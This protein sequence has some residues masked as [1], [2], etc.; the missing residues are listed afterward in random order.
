MMVRDR[1][2]VS[3]IGIFVVL[4]F[5]LTFFFAVLA[6]FFAVCFD[7]VDLVVFFAVEF[8]F[9]ITFFLFIGSVF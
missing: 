7:P 4:V 1:A 6:G 3:A 5:L 2:A 8:A 9:L